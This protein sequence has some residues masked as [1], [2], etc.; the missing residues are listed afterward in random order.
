MTLNDGQVV[1]GTAVYG[2]ISFNELW[3]IE[4]VGA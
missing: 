4:P 2:S 1:D 3:K